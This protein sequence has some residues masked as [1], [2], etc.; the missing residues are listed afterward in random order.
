MRILFFIIIFVM[1]IFLGFEIVQNPGY[2]L[3]VYKDWMVQ[4]PL[5]VALLLLFF[6]LIV[7]HFATRLFYSVIFLKKS[8]RLWWLER[9]FLKKK[10]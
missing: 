8:L 9:L 7:V 4:M 2:A 1:A 6:F 5:W 10:L 3:F